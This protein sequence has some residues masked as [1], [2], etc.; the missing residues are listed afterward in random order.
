LSIKNYGV[1]KGK[2]VNTM[3]GTAEKPHFQVLVQDEERS[4]YRIAINIKSQDYPSEVLYYVGEDFKSDEVTHLPYLDF[5]FTPIVH[6][7]PKIG[8]D[9][10]RGNLL[11]PDKMMPLPA[12]ID[13]PDNDLNDR[14]QNYFSE[15]MKR[16]AII[17][18]FG[19][20]WGP[21]DKP[22]PY[23]HFLP[24]NGI[25][26]IHMNQGNTGHWKK[27]NGVWQDGG[28]LIHFEQENRWVAIFL[29][30]QSQSWC[31]DDN[32]NAIKPVEECNH[33]SV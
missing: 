15:A 20:R 12:E 21:E 29:A 14:I 18:A 8:L 16:D 31:T 32:G 13:G 11:Y 4:K 9:Y 1:L 27:D 7:N 19:Q 26:D 22:D 23:F 30:F 10:I 33:M 25:H 24:G 6:N 3:S 28:I 17:Y 5:G 2:A